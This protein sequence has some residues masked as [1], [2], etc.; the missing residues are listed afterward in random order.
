M[1]A[2]TF[3]RLNAL[4]SVTKTARGHSRKSQPPEEGVTP[5]QA[6]QER[7]ARG[8]TSV[9]KRAPRFE[10]EETALRNNRGVE[11]RA[12]EVGDR[13]RVY[14]GYDYDA[15]WLAAKP[16]GY[17]DRVIEFI[18]GQSVLPAPVVE[19]DEELVLPSGAG[20]ARG[21]EVRGR[22]LVLE[23]GH[24]VTDWSTQNPRVH[25]ELCDFRPERRRWQDRRQGAWVESH[26]TCRIID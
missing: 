5:P 1:D 26:A 10:L 13:I 21:R 20:A 15:D 23:L 6:R 17:T 24:E 14:G 3:V 18:P 9:R 22:F 2:A 4:E 11:P 12:L 7:A 16:E 8:W 25:G 19:L